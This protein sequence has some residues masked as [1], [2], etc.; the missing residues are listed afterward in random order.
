M[1]VLSRRIGE[2]VIIGGEIRVTVLSVSGTQARIGIHAPREI[3]IHRE[4]VHNR[5]FNIDLVRLKEDPVMP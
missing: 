4:E 2:T 3:D 1:L 5:I